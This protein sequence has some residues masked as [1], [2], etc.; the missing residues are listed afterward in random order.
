MAYGVRESGLSY[1]YARFVFAGYLCG[2]VVDLHIWIVIKKKKKKDD[3]ISLMRSYV[4][5]KA[6]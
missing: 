3:W 4:I 5:I 6:V 2:M 1:S